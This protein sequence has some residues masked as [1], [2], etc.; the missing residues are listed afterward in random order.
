MVESPAAVRGREMRE[1][2]RQAA[3]ELI[4]ERGWSA[5][6]TRVLAERAGVTASVVHYHYSSLGSL[7]IE[8]VTQ[9]IEAAT[10]SMA[11]AL[12]GID[13]PEEAVDALLATADDYTADNPAMLLFTEAALAATRDEKLREAVSESLDGFITRLGD[14]FAD[15]D[16][17]EPHDTAAA[18]MA[19]VDGRVIHRALT[20]NRTREPVDTVVRRLVATPNPRST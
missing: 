19:T 15:R 10:Q 13:T 14:W 20:V 1:R 4:P 11:A 9:A 5:V 6:S 18:V 7:L 12:D 2:L 16:V 17:P 3:V 8:A